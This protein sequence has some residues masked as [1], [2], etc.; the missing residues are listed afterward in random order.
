M[1]LSHKLIKFFARAMLMLGLTASAAAWAV[2]DVSLVSVSGSEALLKANCGAGVPIT[3]IQ[4]FKDGT[5]LTGGDLTVNVPAATPSPDIHYTTGLVSGT[6][7]YTA[8][9][10]GLSVAAG[11]AATITVGDPSLT[12]VVVAAGGTGTITSAPAAPSISNCAGTCAANFPLGTTVSLNPTLGANS[13]ITW[14]GDCTGNG[15]CA[16]TM[17]APRTVI[18]TFGNAPVT[19]SCGGLNGVASTNLTSGSVGL[20]SAGG[21]SAF[22]T[23]SASP[24][25]YTWTCSGA[26][27]GG[28]AS[29]SAPN[30]IVGTCGSMNGGPAQPST[31]TTN[32]CGIGGTASAVV[33][34]G[35]TNTFNW[36]CAGANGGA[37]SSQ[38]SVNQAVVNGACGSAQGSNFLTAPAANL[39]ATGIASS[40]ATNGSPTN[41]FTWTCAGQAGGTN[42]GTCT[43]NQTVAAACGT[44]NGGQFS[45]APSTNLCAAGNTV[46]AAPTGAGPW[47]WTCNGINPASTSP[48]C[49]ATV[50]AA[51]AGCPVVDVAAQYPTWAPGEGTGGRPQLSSAASQTIAYKLAGSALVG[52]NN[53][54]NIK[55]YEVAP[56]TTI[57]VSDTPCYINP[58]APGAPA[59]NA[60]TLECQGTGVDRFT[61]TLNYVGATNNSY[62][63]STL[64]NAG[65]CKLAN[66]DS[67]GFYYLNVR[68]PANCGA[69]CGYFMFY[70][71]R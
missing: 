42:S 58:V 29:C 37:T 51:S 2:C 71:P 21:V 66:P 52:A 19:G 70:T 26:N 23:P 27:G 55:F 48:T 40:V 34:N 36:T 30:M 25:N 39:C 15:A 22:V 10:N 62:S 69:N 1:N 16:A 6:H 59:A 17:A 68:A 65:F 38:C 18:A 49:T 47:S 44:S 7:R 67:G 35:T 14:G 64:Y 63:M 53:M 3:G 28:S 33:A 5:S 12:V 45:S 54:G 8:T 43:A 13:S 31:P 9:G 57:E 56:G 32:L 60:T 46:T 50:A 20:C 24:W 4:W 11:L 61:P 41:T